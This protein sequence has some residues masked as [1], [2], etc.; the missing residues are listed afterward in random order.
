MEKANPT[1]KNV[2]KNQMPSLLNYCKEIW[3]YRDLLR[4]LTLRDLK[5]RYAQT[6]LGLLWVIIQPLA[7]LL[8]FSFVFGIAIKI[9][10][11]SQ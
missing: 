11:R 9:D 6:S 5:I 7:T 4:T 3:A 10:N 2:I 8:I 1:P